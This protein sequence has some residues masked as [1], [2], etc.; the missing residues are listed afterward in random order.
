M[1]AT[2]RAVLGGVLIVTVGIESA[3]VRASDDTSNAT[4]A[5]AHSSKAS[6]SST[7]RSRADST[8]GLAATAFAASPAPSAGGLAPSWQTPWNP[9]EAMYRRRTWER[10]V[11]F[12][13]RVATYPLSWVG[14]GTD[15]LLLYAENSRLVQR[16]DF[17]THD[18]PGRYGLGI[19]QASLGDRTGTG[20]RVQARSMFLSGALKNAITAEHSAS[21]R[22]YHNTQVQ[23]F[24]QPA[25]L[26]YAYEWRPE[27][28][29]YGLGM[30]AAESDVSNYAAQA[31]YLRARVQFN[32]NRREDSDVPRSLFTV[33]AGPRTIVTRTGREVDVPSFDDR[34]PELAPERLDRGVEHLTYGMRLATDW[35]DG[36]PHWTRGWRVLLH[37][38]RFDKPLGL[39]LNNP[40]GGGA[41]FTRTIA[42]FETGVSF[43]REPRTLRFLGRVVDVGIGAGAERMQLGDL[44]ALGG[45]EGLGGYEAGRFHDVDQLLTRV[46]YVFPLVQKMEVSLQAD[47]GGVYPNV[48]RSPKLN[49][50]TKSYGVYLRPR[51]RQRVYGRVG[52]EWSTEQVRFRW[53]IGGVD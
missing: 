24:G 31:Q 44:S 40:D 13:Q 19:R 27:E 51:D 29:F 32:W 35:R 30:D 26:E 17:A 8:R 41:Q 37:S 49:D 1:T 33:W 38:E 39:A 18:V 48:W 14:A 34:F 16:L 36:H 50:L 10:V 52:V 9:P 42:E 22:N 11:L 12:P 28:R 25:S 2:L 46:T 4:A 43:W 21:T 5:R 53:K 47:V 15:R 7:V 3:V 20:V 45:R 6:T 23:V